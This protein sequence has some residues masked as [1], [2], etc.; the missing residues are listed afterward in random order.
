[1]IHYIYESILREKQ[2]EVEK[3]ANDAWKYVDFKKETF[4]QKMVNNFRLKLDS[5]KL[6]RQN[7]CISQC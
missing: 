3:I 1:M 7:S 4:F 6:R 2:Q 5:K